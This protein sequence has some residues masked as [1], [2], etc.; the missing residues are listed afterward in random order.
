MLLRFTFVLGQWLQGASNIKSTQQTMV[1]GSMHPGRL[2]E[3]S[4]QQQTSSDK[5]LH[6][7]DFSLGLSS[8]LAFERTSAAMNKEHA[9]STKALHGFRAKPH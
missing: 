3:V 9:R 1:V 8:I 7:G 5:Q 4:M 2:G 6:Q